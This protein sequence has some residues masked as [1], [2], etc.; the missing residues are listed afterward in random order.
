MIVEPL[1]GPDTEPKS[2]DTAGFDVLTE[3]TVPDQEAVIVNDI[4][5]KKIEADQPKLPDK[6]VL[7]NEPIKGP[8]CLSQAIMNAETEHKVQEGPEEHKAPDAKVPENQNEQLGQEKVSGG[9][10][11]EPEQGSE[12]AKTEVAQE[13]MQTRDAKRQKGSKAHNDPEVKAIK[14]PLKANGSVPGARDGRASKEA[15]K[16]E[17]TEPAPL[18]VKGAV[19]AEVQN[20]KVQDN[21]DQKTADKQQKKDDI[22]S[23]ESIT[24]LI[25][26]AAALIVAAIALLDIQGASGKATEDILP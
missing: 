22:G 1:D 18:D 26:S 2:L 17:S 5:E 6:D 8:E 21:K 19:K 20:P 25:T 16:P 13:S 4:P 10:T 12:P 3:D 11:A 7:Q 14:E 23:P 9:T 15:I 24:V